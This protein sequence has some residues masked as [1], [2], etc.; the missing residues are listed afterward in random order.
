MLERTNV[1]SALG[2]LT[3]TGLQK[4]KSQLI[5]PPGPETVPLGATLFVGTPAS[6]YVPLL[7]VEKC[8]SKQKTQD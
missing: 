5:R 7:G 6:P 3:H 8:P 4:W 2:L 1:K